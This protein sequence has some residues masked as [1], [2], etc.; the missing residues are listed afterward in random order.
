MNFN[1]YT[2]LPGSTLGQNVHIG[3]MQHVHKSVDSDVSLSSV[4]EMIDKV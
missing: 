3:L 1:A 4:R 2:S